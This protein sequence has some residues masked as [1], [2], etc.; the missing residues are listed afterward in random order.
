MLFREN[1]D[2]LT[3]LHTPALLASSP[4]PPSSQG[5]ETP[6]LIKQQAVL[7]SNR[8]CFPIKTE[9]F[10]SSNRHRS[11][12]I[13]VSSSAGSSVVGP[14]KSPHSL[15]SL[16]LFILQGVLMELYRPPRPFLDLPLPSL[17][18]TAV[19]VSPLRSVSNPFSAT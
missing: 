11:P 10:S 7:L 14:M 16:H 6:P 18:L 3:P 8:S 9:L 5:I 1:K 19:A 17:L 4:R 12:G 13:L 15:Q 2:M